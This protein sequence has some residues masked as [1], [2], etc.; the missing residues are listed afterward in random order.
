M[1][2]VNIQAKIYSM[3]SVILNLLTM[4]FYYLGINKLFQPTFKI[5]KNIHQM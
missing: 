2:L 1:I 4:F 3:N 5:K